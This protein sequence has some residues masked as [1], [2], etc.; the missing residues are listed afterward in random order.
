MEPGKF[1]SPDST[2]TKIVLVNGAILA[3]IC[4][5]AYFFLLNRFKIDS[6]SLETENTRRTAEVSQEYLKLALKKLT[7][8]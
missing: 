2:R 8:G 7:G 3:L 6:L 5:G 1:L 4:V